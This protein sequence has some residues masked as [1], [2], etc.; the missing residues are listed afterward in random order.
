MAKILVIDDEPQMRD[1]LQQLLELD[2]HTVTLA[3][4]GDEGLA[5][6]ARM[7]PNLVITDIIMPG[8]DG[9]ETLVEIRRQDATTPV[10][11]ISG[12]RRSLSASFNLDSSELVGANAMLPKPFTRAQLQAAVKKCLP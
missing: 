11:A 7:R 2:G 8:K 10:I 5:S 12:G 4:N 9:I 1:M 3:A 6:F